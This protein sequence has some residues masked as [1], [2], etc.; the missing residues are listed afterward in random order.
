MCAALIQVRGCMCVRVKPWVVRCFVESLG[1]AFAHVKCEWVSRGRVCRGL[2]RIAQHDLPSTSTS[3]V[4]RETH[5]RTRMFLF[6]AKL[7]LVDMG[8]ICRLGVEMMPMFHQTCGAGGVFIDRLF[9]LLLSFLL[10]RRLTSALVL[11]ESTWLY[12]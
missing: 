5:R 10:R 6:P 1:C 7:G 11:A 3:M 9:F 12:M 2:G 4:T 8:R